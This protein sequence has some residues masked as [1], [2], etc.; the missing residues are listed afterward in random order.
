[1]WNIFKGPGSKR[2]GPIFSTGVALKTK[3]P[4]AGEFSSSILKSLT[5]SKIVCLADMHGQC[6]RLRVM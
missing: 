6:L 5:G 4:Q 3:I 2:A 1:M